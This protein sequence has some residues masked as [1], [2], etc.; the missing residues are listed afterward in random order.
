MCFIA[1]P[2]FLLN[3]FCGRLIVMPPSARSHDA[4][5]RAAG[6]PPGAAGGG[7][8]RLNFLYVRMGRRCGAQHHGQYR[9][10]TAMELALSDHDFCSSDVLRN[11]PETCHCSNRTS[12][13]SYVQSHTSLR[14]ER[15]P[16]LGPAGVVKVTSTP[17]WRRAPRWAARPCSEARAPA[18]MTPGLDCRKGQNLCQR[19]K[20]F[21]GLLLQEVM[22]TARWG[23]RWPPLR[24]KVTG[25]TPAFG[26]GP[27]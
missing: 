23:M 20:I 8:G 10:Y 6:G 11:Y 27:G 22:E 3:L 14:L 19:G 17:L 4:A 5:A 21:Y 15:H 1:L 26:S 13:V 25:D 18:L 24:R 7:T 12:R 16:C 2:L 9:E